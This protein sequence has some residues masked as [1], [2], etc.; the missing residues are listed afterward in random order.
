MKDSQR[1]SKGLS[2]DQPIPLFP[3]CHCTT[4]I[5]S[6]LPLPSCLY[7]DMDLGD[8]CAVLQTLLLI[9]QC[10]GGNMNAN[11]IWCSFLPPLHTKWPA[12]SLCVASKLRNEAT[13]G[14]SSP[15]RFF[16]DP[17]IADF[18]PWQEMHCLVTKA[19]WKKK[20]YRVKHRGLPGYYDNCLEA[21]EHTCEA[22]HF[23]MTWAGWQVTPVILEP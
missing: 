11:L 17:S 23:S 14:D 2:E 22:M 4:N 6:A 8:S 20:S 16:S 13:R 12:Q 3:G 21:W 19:E 7:W 5:H 1:R 9:C 15:I 18:I 10:Q